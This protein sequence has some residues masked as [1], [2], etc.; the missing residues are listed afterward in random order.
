MASSKAEANSHSWSRREAKSQFLGTGEHW[1]KHHWSCWL[2]LG[3]QDCGGEAEVTFPSP[4]QYGLNPFPLAGGREHRNER[5]GRTLFSC[6]SPT[7]LVHGHHQVC[8][9][10]F[11]CFCFFFFSG[12][13][14]SLCSP[15]WPGPRCVDQL[16]SDLRDR[17]AFAGTKGVAS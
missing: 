12:Y 4:P 13:R 2:W 16:A 17:P 10:L 6:S 1:A 9:F 11:V 8:Y 7:S 5:N 3:S 14:V 15:G